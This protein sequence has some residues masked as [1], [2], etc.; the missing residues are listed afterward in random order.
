MCATIKS[1]IMKKIAPVVRKECREYYR[2]YGEA[3]ARAASEMYTQT[4]RES[5][6]YFY[7]DYMPLSYDRTY[8]LLNNAYEQYLNKEAGVYYGGVK[9]S[10]EHMQDYVSSYDIDPDTEK[11]IPGGH[12]IAKGVVFH[13]TWEEGYHGNPDQNYYIPAQTSPSP[14]EWFEAQIADPA[15]QDRI[16]AIAVAAAQSRKYTYI[17]RYFI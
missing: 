10:P 9:I 16:N 3:Y 15:Y 12:V 13:D 14:Q 17:N 1:Q 8:D 7:N 2:T 4:A 11:V 5:L 6:E